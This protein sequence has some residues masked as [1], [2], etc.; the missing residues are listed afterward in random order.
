M[1]QT[2][3]LLEVKLLVDPNVIKETLSRMGIVDKKNKIIYQSCHL[4][5]QFDTYYLVHFKQLFTLTTGK[6]GYHGFGNVSLE[7]L[8]RRNSIA[9]W[10]IKWHM[11]SINDMNEIVPHRTKFDIVSHNDAINY[12][13]VRKF[14]INNIS[15]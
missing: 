15:E 5:K 12:K 6:N 13:K 11:I 9:L 14:N 3:K 2:N 4:L 7:D 1:F 8:E 10:L